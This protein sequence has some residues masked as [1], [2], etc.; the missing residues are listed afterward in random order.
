M[1]TSQFA[2]ASS[3]LAFKRYNLLTCSLDCKAG[4]QYL[5]S[6]VPAG[7]VQESSY[8][9]TVLNM[10]VKNKGKS[11]S[12][13]RLE[14]VNVGQIN[15]AYYANPLSWFFEVYPLKPGSYSVSKPFVA[16]IISHVPSQHSR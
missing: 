14:P 9:I 1:A 10:Q 16:G 13:Q 8:F 5:L 6:P 15:D 4:V 3:P 7:C 12:L 11:Y 2:P